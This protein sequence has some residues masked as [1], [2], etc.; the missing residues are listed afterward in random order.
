MDSSGTAWLIDSHSGFEENLGFY[1]WLDF[2]KKWSVTDLTNGR[3]R[4]LTHTLS[5]LPEWKP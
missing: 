4:K 3:L 1:I 5:P 2:A